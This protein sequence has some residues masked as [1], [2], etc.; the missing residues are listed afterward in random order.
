[1]SQRPR[2]L[3]KSRS[4]AWFSPG[5]LIV[6]V[7]L[8]FETGDIAKAQA[9][10]Q[11][12]VQAVGRLPVSSAEGTTQFVLRAPADRIAAIAA[13]HGLTVVGPADEHAHDVFLVSGPATFFNG[14]VSALD[15][16]SIRG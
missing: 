15:R 1:M 3:M 16:D 10:Q 14:A 11:P 13:R 6:I 2:R 8:V 7:A 5:L 9:P 12:F 4:L